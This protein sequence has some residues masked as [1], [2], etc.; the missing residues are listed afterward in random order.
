MRLCIMAQMSSQVRQFR[1]I[2]IKNLDRQI[3]ISQIKSFIATQ[4][5]E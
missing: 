3:T 4:G 1:V 2:H 5:H